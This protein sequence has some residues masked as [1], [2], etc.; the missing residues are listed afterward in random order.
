MKD[1]QSK[2]DLVG[3]EWSN[4]EGEVDPTFVPLDVMITNI[5]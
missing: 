5:S 4:N 1:C 3:K 2:D